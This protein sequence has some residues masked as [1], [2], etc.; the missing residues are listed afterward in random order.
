MTALAR[1]KRGFS[2]VELMIVVGVV[3][4]LATL[5]V[6]TYHDF[7]AKAKQMEAKTA[8]SHMANLQD[9]YYLEHGHYGSLRQIG[10]SISGNEYECEH[11]NPP[12]DAQMCQTVDKT[13]SRYDYGMYTYGNNGT[14][15]WRGS[16]T[17]PQGKINPTSS[18]AGDFWLIYTNLKKPI[19]YPSPTYDYDCS[20]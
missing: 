2:I 11:H 10:W 6:P 20:D 14:A 12:S 13:D 7:Q 9:A 16:A 15:L 5:A 8:L 3:S 18:C 17:A 4:V 19:P 1:E